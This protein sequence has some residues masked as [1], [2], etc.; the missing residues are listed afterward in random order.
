MN[1]YDPNR[2]E[3]CDTRLPIKMNYCPNCGTKIPRRVDT[4]VEIDE[5]L[6]LSKY[7]AAQGR[8]NNAQWRLAQFKHRVACGHMEDDEV[9]ELPER[10]KYHLDQI[11]IERRSVM[12]FSKRN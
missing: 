2:F 6:R 3:C 8:L 9:M 11:E 10:L 1:E 4:Q 5:R 12:K 7:R